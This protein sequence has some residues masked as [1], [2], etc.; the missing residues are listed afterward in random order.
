MRKTVFQGLKFYCLWGKQNLLIYGGNFFPE[1]PCSINDKMLL[2]TFLVCHLDNKWKDTLFFWVLRIS[3]SICQQKEQIYKWKLFTGIYWFSICKSQS[4][5]LY[6]IFIHYTLYILY[7]I[8]YIIILYIIIFITTLLLHNS[9][10]IKFTF[11]KCTIQGILLY[12]QRCATTI[13][14]I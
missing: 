1:G 11:L 6:I 8:I 9:L 5:N 13:T 14:T 4:S 2:K 7:I 10:T 3:R 12:W